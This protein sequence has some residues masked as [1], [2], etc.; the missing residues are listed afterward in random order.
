MTQPADPLLRTAQPVQGQP[1]ENIEREG[2]PEGTAPHEP[3]S[4]EPTSPYEDASAA[5][6]ET[7]SES[8]RPP[9]ER[10]DDE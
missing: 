2:E 4:P 10:I 9:P 1:H 8:V 6:D 3:S 7:D 5:E